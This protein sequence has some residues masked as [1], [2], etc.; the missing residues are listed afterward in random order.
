RGWC[1]VLVGGI[2]SIGGYFATSALSALLQPTFGWRIM[3]LINLPIALILV[4][5]SAVLQ[6]SAR[7]LQSMG[8]VREARETLARFG[9]TVGA[10]PAGATPAPAQALP[11][12]SPV[13]VRS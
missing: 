13:K 6:E 2:G 8:R 4:A 12:P 11:A 3:W 7:F 1:L 5:L 10:A 9:I